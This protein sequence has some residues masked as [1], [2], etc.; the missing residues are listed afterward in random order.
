MVK[1]AMF[2]DLKTIM[3]M[4]ISIHRSIDSGHPRQNIGTF[5]FV[6]EENSKIYTKMKND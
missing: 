2:M 1:Y 3:K 6:E 4:S 5:F